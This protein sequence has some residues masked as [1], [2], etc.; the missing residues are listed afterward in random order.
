MASEKWK[1]IPT[2]KC[3]KFYMDEIVLQ[4]INDAI[5]ISKALY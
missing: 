2:F 5:M 1:S 4:M 3:Y